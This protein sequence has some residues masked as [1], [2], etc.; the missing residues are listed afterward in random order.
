MNKV[1]HN[2]V[3]LLL[4]LLPVVM[5][6]EVFAVHGG[7]AINLFVSNMPRYSI[8]LDLTYIPLAARDRSINDINEHLKNITEKCS[9]LFHGIHII[10]NY[11]TCKLLCEYKGYQVKI[12]VNQTKR[13]IIGGSVQ[14]LPLCGKAQ[15]EFGIYCEAQVVPMTLLYGGKIA[16]ALSRQHP[17]DMFD[18]KYMPIHIT[19]AREGFIFCL[20]GS[21]RP[22]YESIAPKHIDQR[23]VMANQFDGMTDISFSYKEFEE[24]RIRLVQDINNVLTVEDKNLLLSFESAEPVWEN[25]DFEYFKDYP[26][27][28]W[29]LMNLKKLK[30]SNPQKLKTEV[31]KLKAYLT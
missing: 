31:D 9:R 15:N 18:V 22:I 26:S 28:K 11:N 19:E 10:P 13:G 8:D 30:K 12:E 16:A 4:R 21:D 20:L 6:E 17:R 14:S 25:Y 23:E 1:Y 3:E 5:G 27:V 2:K 29:K 24:T 7:T